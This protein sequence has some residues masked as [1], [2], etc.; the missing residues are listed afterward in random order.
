M[1]KKIGVLLGILVLLMPFVLAEVNTTTIETETGIGIG[2]G[3]SP[4]NSCPVIVQ[5]EPCIFSQEHDATYGDYLDGSVCYEVNTD[6]NQW[7]LELALDYGWARRS[8]AFEGETVTFYVDVIDE[9]GFTDSCVNVK[10]ILKQGDDPGEEAGCALVGTESNDADSTKE[11]G[12]FECTFTVEPAESGM[13][14]EYWVTVEATQCES[15]CLDDAAGVISL[16][17]NP[18]VGLEIDSQDEFG[19]MYDVNGDALLDGVHAGDVVYTPYFTVE[20]AAEEDTGLYLLMKM[21][22]ED[23]WDYDSSAAICPTSNVLDVE[24]WLE[25]KASHLNVQQDWDY[26]SH[27]DNYI[28]NEP[29]YSNIAGNFLGVGDDIT[30]RL[31]LTIPTPCVGN[32]DDGGQI[33]FVGEV[34]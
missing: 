27:D 34:I 32:F 11:L 18:A 28:F 16:Y 5:E 4:E 19:L 24:D 8:Y 13:I 15:E 29:D 23:M 21:Y 31:R 17:L 33:V 14:G 10:V 3:V 22:G 25:Y 12:H 9:D 6:T 26:I 20:N 7:L 1:N 2:V 30:M